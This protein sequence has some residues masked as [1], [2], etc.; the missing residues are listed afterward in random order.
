MKRLQAFK[1]ELPSRPA[2][3]AFERIRLAPRALVDVSRR[4]QKVTVLGLHFDSPFGISPMAPLGLTRHRADMA[5]AR[6]ARAANVPF[7]LSTHAFVPFGRVAC[8]A[9]GAPWLQVYPAIDRGRAKAELEHARQAVHALH[10][11][12]ALV[13][14]RVHVFMFGAG[15]V[16]V[17]FAP[18]SWAVGGF[19]ALGIVWYVYRVVMWKPATKKS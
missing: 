8:D 17:N 12:F 7:V 19:I 1:D 18:A 14:H 4:S 9:G 10:D 15:V 3:A 6:A 5:L 2:R 13:R 16:N 11:E